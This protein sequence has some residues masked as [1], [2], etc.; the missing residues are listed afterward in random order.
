MQGGR[1]RLADADRLC[2]TGAG[3]RDMAAGAEAAEPVCAGLA[4]PEGGGGDPIGAVGGKFEDDPAVG[5]VAA[6][7]DIVIGEEEAV[8]PGHHQK[9]I[10]TFGAEIELNAL[11]ARAGERIGILIFARAALAVAERQLAVDAGPAR[12]SPRLRHAGRRAKRR[13]RRQEKPQM[14]HPPSAAGAAMSLRARNVT[15]LAAKA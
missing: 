12:G 8:R 5:L 7:L 1:D 9:S 3:D 4:G 14:L 2:G 11:A 10:E 6:A 15:P 13:R